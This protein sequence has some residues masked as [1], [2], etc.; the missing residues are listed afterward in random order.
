MA[1]K[2]EEDKSKA[3]MPDTSELTNVQM[4][5][6]LSEYARMYLDTA[7]QE[8]EEDDDVPLMVV[9]GSKPIN[10]KT[11]LEI[12]RMAAASHC[13]RKPYVFISS[14]GNHAQKDGSVTMEHIALITYARSKNLKV[15]Y[16]PKELLE[17][18]K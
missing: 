18:L 9:D 12:G 11:Y 1:R 16:N 17:W 10:N 13:E 3:E 14:L 2:K 7:F 4:V 6:N 5:N 15:T 8:T